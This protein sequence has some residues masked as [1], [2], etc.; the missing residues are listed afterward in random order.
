MSCGKSGHVMCLTLPMPSNRSVYCPDCG[1]KGHNGDYVR[2]PDDEPSCRN[3]RE[4]NLL[5]PPLILSLSV[6]LQRYHRRSDERPSA[7]LIPPPPQGRSQTYPSHHSN[8]SH[9]HYPLDPAPRTAPP[10]RN[11]TMGDMMTN[12]SKSLTNSREVTTRPG[13][14][15]SRG[16]GRS[17]RGGR[18]RGEYNPGGGGR[19]GRKDDSQSLSNGTGGK[20]HGRIIHR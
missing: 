14:S 11:E 7:P 2:D 18:G 12:R 17:G 8:G 20:H 13:G 19:G 3:P 16:G 6:E 4:N 1:R 9:T 10:P 5:P 15:F